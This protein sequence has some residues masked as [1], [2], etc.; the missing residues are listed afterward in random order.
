MG[1]ELSD[2]E[3]NYAQQLLKAN[4][5]K[6]NGFQSTLVIRKMAQFENSIQ[7]VHCAARHHWI[8]ATTVAASK[9]KSKFFT[10]SSLTVTRK[11]C[12]PCILYFSLFQN[13]QPLRCVSARSKLVQLTVGYFR[14]PTQWPWFM[15]RTLAS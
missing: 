1:K 10:Q 11:L 13:I 14:L 8:L 12:K 6:F 9:E 2:I 7:I 5:L 15:E 3:I 4:H